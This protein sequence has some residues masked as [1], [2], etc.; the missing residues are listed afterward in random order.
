MGA[1]RASSAP[2]TSRVARHVTARPAPGQRRRRPAASGA[3]AVALVAPAPVVLVVMRALSG[4]E[5]IGLVPS[6]IVLGAAVVLVV[7]AALACFDGTRGGSPGEAQQAGGQ[8]P[9]L[10]SP[11]HLAPADP[12]LVSVERWLV[13]WPG[14]AGVATVAWCGARAGAA[15]L[16]VDLGWDFAGWPHRAWALGGAVGCLAALQLPPI[17]RRAVHL[18]YWAVGLAGTAITVS[19]LV[20]VAEGRL[21]LKLVPSGQLWPPSWAQGAPLGTAAAD[22]ATLS[23]LAVALLAIRPAMPG[24]DRG[25]RQAATAMTVVPICCWALAVPLLVRA[26]TAGTGRATVSG[27]PGSLAQSLQGLLAPLAGAGAASATRWALFTACV[28][29]GLGLLWNATSLA[30]ASIG[31]AR[32]DGPWTAAGGKASAPGHHVP[33]HLG[34][35]FPTTARAAALSALWGA[36]A[37]AIGPS[38]WLLTLLGVAAAGALALTAVAPGCARRHDRLFRTARGLALVVSVPVLILALG[39]GSAKALAVAVAAGMF[40]ALAMAE[41]SFRLWAQRSGDTAF[42]L[43]EQALPALAR[44]AEGLAQGTPGRPTVPGLAALDDPLLPLLAGPRPPKQLRPLVTS[45]GEAARQ[46]RRLADG[47]EA[48]VHSERRRLNE[49]VDER[50]SALASANRNLAG[51]SWERRQLL[52]RTIRATEAERARLAANLHDG[53]VQRL[54]TL[55]LV[56]DRCML[57]LERGDTAE[58]AELAK[59]ARSELTEEIARLRRMMTELRPPV[60]DEHGL[61]SALQDLVSGWSEATG[62]PAHIELSPHPEMGPEAETVAYRVVQEALTNVAKHAKAGLATVT[63]GSADEGVEVAVRDNGRGFNSLAQPDR[64]REGHF[65]VMVMRERVELA[66]GRFELWSAPLMGTRVKIWLPRLARESLSEA[67]GLAR[68]LQAVNRPEAITSGRA[69]HGVEDLLRIEM[70]GGRSG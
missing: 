1:I 19:G 28:A 59:R 44:R 34:H 32:A 16:L 68:L 21:R 20:A 35:P 42:V 50:M 57:R 27:G 37:A 18:S 11:W 36:L 4:S 64:A 29:G 10:L 6:G 66:S 2:G 40:G 52:D 63:I 39:Y 30:S 49:L 62:V 48:A 31:A 15:G 54:A 8:S 9:A 58:G 51:A 65:G 25:A 14:V 60:L 55:G 33:Q 3:R 12:G 56:L 5:S 47:I 67:E 26:G 46:A 7:A 70:S 45:L 41:A 53:P 17:A 38:P 69:A 23:L 61:D 43:A 24:S 13:N 22:V